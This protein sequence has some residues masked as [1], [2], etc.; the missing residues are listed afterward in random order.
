MNRQEIKI[1]SK[2][3][4]KG[5]W[6]T[7]WLLFFLVPALTAFATLLTLGA[8]AIIVSG[9]LTMGTIMI[10][11]TIA[12]GGKGD[13]K[14]VINPLK[15]R[16][17]DAF[18]VGLIISI[19]AFIPI[20]GIILEL[21]FAEAWIILINDPD[22]SGLDALKRSREIMKGHKGEL[23][24]LYLSFIGWFLLA[25]ITFG[26]ALLYVV[27]YLKTSTVMYLQ[28]IYYAETGTLAGT[29]AQKKTKSTKKTNKAES[30]D[31]IEFKDEDINVSKKASKGRSASNGSNSKGL[32][33]VLVVVI[34]IA[35]AFAGFYLYRSG[36]IASKFG[37]IQNEQVIDEPDETQMHMGDEVGGYTD[38]EYVVGNTYYTQDALRVREGPGTNYR[39]IYRDEMDSTEEMYCIDDDNAVLEEDSPVECLE[40]SG[41]W[42]RIYSGWICCFDDGERLVK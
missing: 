20:L 23:F 16:L 3:Y 6:D 5:N 9:P 4:M 2:E 28:S 35:V 11:Y 30:I 7:A 32:V 14:T 18:V 10:Y 26:I 24:V 42:M 33:I 39:W 36:F 8:G 12:L 17:S 40:I 19:A 29:A 31:Y 37:S 13:W 34:I 38:S 25:C 15:N 41:D 1:R 22:I 21:A 27:P